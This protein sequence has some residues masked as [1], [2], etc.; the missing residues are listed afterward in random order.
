MTITETRPVAKHLPM[1]ILAPPLGV[2]VPDPG[3]ASI[4]NHSSGAGVGPITETRRATS[5]APQPKG[6]A[7]LGVKQPDLGHRGPGDQSTPAGVGP[8]LYDPALYLLAA[9]LDAIES[10]RIA[11]G[12]RHRM[13]TRDVADS[14]G[15]IRG[16]G[17]T[18]DN[19]AVKR[20]AVMLDALEKTE[21]E[22]VLGLN[23][24]M[25]AH[26]LGPWQKQTRG[27]GEKQLARLLACIGDPY[28][29]TLHDRPRTVSELWAYCGLHTVSVSPPSARECTEPNRDPQVAARRTKG[30][31]AN[32]STT[33]KT[34]VYLI[35]ESCLK[36]GN[37]REVYDDHK[38]RAASA[39]HEIK[40]APC[41]GVEGTAL[42]PGHQ[43]ARAMR[44]MSKAILKDLWVEARRIHLLST[45][46]ESE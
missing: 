32:W 7:S 26:P 20:S 11:T 29:N 24:L 3:Q 30:Q 10:L 22:V 38:S 45:G 21:H 35:A 1:P 41:G 9:Q 14:D 13:A 37:Y 17:L 2:N 44:A 15:H 34:R 6:E 40:C 33:A 23:R 16:L 5:H 8:I 18:E 4:E 12:N 46:G 27:V 36:A 25:R 31:R 39:V 42:K 19:P 28:W 43:H